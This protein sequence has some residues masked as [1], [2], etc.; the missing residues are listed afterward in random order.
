ME[1]NSAPAAAKGNKIYFYEKCKYNSE[2]QR[3]IMLNFPK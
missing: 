1:H 3:I 2:K